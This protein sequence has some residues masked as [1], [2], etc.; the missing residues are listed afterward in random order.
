M[1]RSVG[2]KVRRKK[3]KKKTKNEEQILGGQ[4][5]KNLGTE[6]SKGGTGAVLR[7]NTIEL[8]TTIR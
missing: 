5:E 3:K 4:V 2:G 6:A 8:Y 7:Y 1:R